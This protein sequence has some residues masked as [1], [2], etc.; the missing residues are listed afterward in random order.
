MKLLTES[1]QRQ[2]VLGE[3]KK[4]F[5]ANYYFFIERRETPVPITLKLESETTDD[6]VQ[7]ETKTTI[8]DLENQTIEQTN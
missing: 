8:D 1:F 6:S 4:W 2:L 3:F 5:F 7:D